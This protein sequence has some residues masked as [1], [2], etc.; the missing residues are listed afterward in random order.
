MRTIRTLAAAAVLALAVGCGTTPPG[1]DETPPT[2]T[3]A[4]P[5]PTASASPTAPSA[6]PSPTGSPTPS[7]TATV[8]PT[9]T[10]TATATPTPTPPTPRPTS[11]PSGLLGRD[12][13]R[14]PTS[15]RVVALTFDC[16]A[17]ADGVAPI[18]ATLA[19]AHAPGTFF[20]TGDWVGDYPTQARQIATA[21][22][23]V[24][25]HTATHPHFSTLTDVQKRAEILGAAGTIA[26]AGHDPRPFFRF[27]F[28]E[29]TTADIRL[30]NSLGYLS[31]RW[32]VD[33]LGWKGTSGGQSAGT[34]LA[35]V[36]AGLQP[37]EI[38][39]MHVGSHPTD[40]STLDA[41]ALPSVIDAIR[42]RGYTLVT[43]AA[44]LD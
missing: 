1:S 6:T 35:K 44:L 30:A 31:V 42:A 41:E 29:R 15:S 37:G 7:R 11:L 33:T 40:H 24:G 18:L 9:A 17:N 13:E 25:N 36:L 22:F 23:E 20:M 34:V 43:L 38:V 4:T 14:I 21:G 5:S 2:P 28:G 39:L 26:A 12:L 32:T 10:P 16:G 27:P 19:A 3:G 8:S